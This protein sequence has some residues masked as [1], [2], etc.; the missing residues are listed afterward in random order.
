MWGIPYKVVTK[1]LN[2][3][4]PGTLAASRELELAEQ[5]FPRSPETRWEEID[6]S[7]PRGLPIPLPTAKDKRSFVLS[8]LLTAARR[9]PGEK[10]PGPDVVPNEVLKN[11]IREDPEALLS[12]YNVCWG[13][14]AFP[15]I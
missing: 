8:E 11:F 13:R 9:L 12:F 5:L 2:R 10:A 4:P 3:C 6:T 7:G 14:A 15:K 1:K